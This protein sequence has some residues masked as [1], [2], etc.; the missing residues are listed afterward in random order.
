MVRLRDG[1]R[2]SILVYALAV[3][4]MGATAAIAQVDP[5]ASAQYPTNGY[6]VIICGNSV[7]FGND[8]DALIKQ[9]L[10]EAYR[11]FRYN[12]GFDPNNLWVLVDGGDDSWTEGEFNALP[13]TTTQVGTVFQTVGQRMWDR[14]DIPRN[15][16]VV[17]GGHGSRG[18]A[19]VATSMKVQLNNAT[20]WD[21][22]F[23]SS[24][25]GKINTNSHNASPIERLDLIM[26][27]CDGGGLIDDFRTFFSTCRG[28]GKWPNAKH[29]TAMTAGD[30]FDITSGLF[31]VYMV[32]SM[33]ASGEGVP[34]LNGNGVL[35]IYEYYNHAAH[36]DITNPTVPY[37]PYIPDTLYQPSDYYIPIPF[38]GD[39]IHEHPL[40]YEWNATMSLSVSH[41]LES[42]GQ[43]EITPAPSDPNAP[44]Y[45]YDT[46]VTLN[47]VPVPDRIFKYWEV[48]DPQ[49]PGDA[50]YMATDANNPLAVVM[51][52]DRQVTAVFGCSSGAEQAL[53]LTAV[54]LLLLGGVLRLMRRR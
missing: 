10:L 48:Y 43:V 1:L 52:A 32:Q 18:T 27:M 24:Y 4:L 38:D 19:G 9:L 23:I 45:S 49:H 11:C 31:G 40:Y 8:T 7:V 30:G 50:N 42:Q 28:N 51:T 36:V 14:P 6:G 5:N 53:P 2:N 54:G 34:D 3:G 16:I 20:V 22:T 47:A 13:A 21:T 37:T 41:R 15:L 46:R 35:S 33:R 17:I 12:L 39:V 25:F 29:I 26:T 44:A